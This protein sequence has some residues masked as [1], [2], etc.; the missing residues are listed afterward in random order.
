MKSSQPAAVLIGVELAA[1]K[2]SAASLRAVTSSKTV[3]TGADKW[4]RGDWGRKTDH[5]NGERAQ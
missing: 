3:P 4:R 2:A 1:I 5:L